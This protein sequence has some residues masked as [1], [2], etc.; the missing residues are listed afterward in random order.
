MDENGKLLSGGLRDPA[1]GS[2]CQQGV[3]DL[4]YPAIAQETFSEM[5]G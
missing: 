1:M 2:E 4:I 3:N 5:S